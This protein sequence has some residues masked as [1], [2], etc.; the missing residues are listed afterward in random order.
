MRVVYSE[1]VVRGAGSCRYVARYSKRFSSQ[2]RTN[3]VIKRVTRARKLSLCMRLPI[4]SLP[5][6]P[7]FSPR[8]ND[9]ANLSKLSV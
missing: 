3:D 2:V 5:H 1:H 4:L 7:Q 6:A 9:D 8:F